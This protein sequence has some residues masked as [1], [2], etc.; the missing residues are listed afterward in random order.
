MDIFFLFFAFLIRG[1]EAEKMSVTGVSGQNITITCSFKNKDNYIKY[2]CKD[3]CWN[4]DVLI[5]SSVYKV[6]WDTNKYSIRDDKS[7]FHV[8]IFNLKKEDSGTYKCGVEVSGWW[9]PLQTVIITVKE[10]ITPEKEPTKLPE[11]VN[12]KASSS[13]Q[14]TEPTKLPQQVHP[15]TSL[16]LK[17]LFIGASLA[18]IVLVLAVVILI[19]FRHQKG[20]I[21][22]SSD[23]LRTV[24]AQRQDSSN[25]I[26][27]SS[28]MNPDCPHY[29]TISYNSR[30]DN[31]HVPPQPADVT[32]SL[33]KFS[34]EADSAIYCNL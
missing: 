14:E 3:P 23:Q 8:T 7:R 1:L 18:V 9:D 16:S 31:S 6:K 21:C 29:S 26:A 12:P 20:H 10:A 30:R 32:Y 33:I 15:N 22:P 13:S 25:S 5:S 19:Y 2:F 28:Q 24:A 17:P 27:A 11:Q 4:E 34:A